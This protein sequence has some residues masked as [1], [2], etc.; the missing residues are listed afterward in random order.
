MSQKNTFD[1]KKLLS[2]LLISKF[3]L[4]LWN[5]AEFQKMYFKTTKL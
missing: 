1:S 5:S 3:F 4:I 2:A